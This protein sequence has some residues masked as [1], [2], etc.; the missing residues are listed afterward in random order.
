MSLFPTIV[1]GNKE[2]IYKTPP[3]ARICE[4]INYF[5]TRPWILKSFRYDSLKKARPITQ[6][7]HRSLTTKFMNL[8]LEVDKKK[9]KPKNLKKNFL[10]NKN[11]D[12]CENLFKEINKDYF[13]TN[14]FKNIILSK[15]TGF[16]SQ[17]CHKY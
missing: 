9:T 2:P 7:E 10:T 13:T 15:K 14:V 11:T 8:D 16:T 5:K 4:K 12:S 17:I 1:T 3:K 6:I